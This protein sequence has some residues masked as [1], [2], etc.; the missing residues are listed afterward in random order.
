M[1]IADEQID[2]IGKSL[3]G[4]T[5]VCARCHDHKFDPIP[6]ADY[7]GLAG[8]FRSTNTFYGGGIKR[9]KDV[10]EK[11]KLAVALGE[12][13]DEIV[14]RINE[15][16]QQLN[17]LTKEQQKLS[18]EVAAL[19]KKLPKDWKNR[20]QE[21]QQKLDNIASTTTEEESKEDPR[22]QLEEKERKQLE[23]MENFAGSQ[24]KLEELKTS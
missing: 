20:L 9:P 3:L 16:D 24:E 4:L 12:D 14:K 18:K 11:A 22:Q 15:H 23:Q 6:T 7:Y 10:A 19:Q 1:D 13:A 17:K 21:L 5:V 2:V 8:I